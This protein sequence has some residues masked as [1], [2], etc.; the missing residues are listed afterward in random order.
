[1]ANSGERD[2]LVEHN[3]DANDEDDGGTTRL[4]Q[5]DYSSTPEP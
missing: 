3:D 1:M 2:P 4:F 5:P